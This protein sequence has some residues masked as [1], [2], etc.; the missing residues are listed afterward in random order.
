MPAI[1]QNRSDAFEDLPVL[2]RMEREEQTR[3]GWAQVFAVGLI[4]LAFGGL[5]LLLYLWLQVCE[6]RRDGAQRPE[7]WRRIGGLI[8]EHPRAEL[9]T[10]DFLQSLAGKIEPPEIALLAHR[11]QPSGPVRS[12]VQP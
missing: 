2:I 7:E 12:Y 3:E 8:D 11:R 6:V 9:L 5:N 10:A 1:G 4:G